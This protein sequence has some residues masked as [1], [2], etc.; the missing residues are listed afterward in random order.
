MA[1]RFQLNLAAKADSKEYS[2]LLQL[3]QLSFELTGEDVAKIRLQ[4]LLSVFI[5]K[6]F[7]KVFH[8]SVENLVELKVKL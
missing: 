2:E 6:V 3:L 5:F 8:R 4:R 1:S 7:H